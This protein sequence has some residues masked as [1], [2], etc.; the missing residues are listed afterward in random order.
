MFTTHSITTKAPMHYPMHNIST[1]TPQDDA[2]S[3]PSLDWIL[4]I[5]KHFHNSA[6]LTPL[7]NVISSSSKAPLQEDESLDLKIAEIIND[8]NLDV[9]QATKLLSMLVEKKSWDTLPKDLSQNLNYYL[10]G[11]K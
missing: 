6:N 1:P 8:E 10:Y 3:Q 5:S 9:W 11:Q 4:D 2:I 7:I